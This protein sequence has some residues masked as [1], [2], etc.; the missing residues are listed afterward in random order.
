MFLPF[1]AAILIPFIYNKLSRLH[2][3][4]I[5]LAVPAVIFIG[6]IRYIPATSSGETFLFTL[7][8]IPSFNIN[9]HTYLD[10]LS[11]IFGLLITGIGVLVVLYSIYYLSAERSEEHTSELQSRGH[12]VCRLLLEK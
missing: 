3:G 10:G 12:L 7:N 4:W 1:L 6:L 9:L 11:I 2:I 8:W 5:V